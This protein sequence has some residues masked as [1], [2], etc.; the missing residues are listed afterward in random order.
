MQIHTGFGDKD[1]DL[2]LSNPLHLRTLL[3]DKR[4]SKC[5]LVLLHASYP[6]SKEASYL[7]SVYSQVL[8]GFSV[9]V[10][11]SA[12][13]DLLIAFQVLVKAL[14]SMDPGDDTELHGVSKETISRIH[15]WSHVFTN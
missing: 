14:V 2:R 13:V 9:P 11:A 5:R 3:E 8:L 1:L 6:F 15:G 10:G 4:F 7:A 12:W